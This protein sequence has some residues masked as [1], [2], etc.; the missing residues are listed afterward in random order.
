MTQT[1]IQSPYPTLLKLLFSDSIDVLVANAEEVIFEKQQQKAALLLMNIG[2]QRKAFK[3]IGF[4]S[5]TYQGIC[6]YL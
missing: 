4:I 1:R 5:F 3:V 2:E 6:R